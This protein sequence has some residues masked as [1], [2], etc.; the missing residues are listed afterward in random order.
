MAARAALTS[1]D[2]ALAVEQA[3]RAR[4][5]HLLHGRVR[6]AARAQATAGRSLRYW[7]RFGEARD[8][9]TAALA[10]LRDDPDADTVRALNEVA[11]VE[12]F[13][14]SPDADALSAE[15]L[16]RG[17]ALAVDDATLAGLFV[18]RG[19]YLI[20]VNRL[21]EGAAYLREAARLAGLAADTL[22]LSRARLNLASALTPADPAAGAAAARDAA[23]NARQVGARDYL[24]FAVINLAQALLMLGDWDAVIAE[25]GQAADAD[26][27]NMGVFTGYRAWVTALRGDVPNAQA[28]LAGLDELRASEDV[29]DQS[30]IAL[31]EAFTAA[32]RRQ[33]AAALCRARAAF[34]YAPTLGISHEA[35]RWAWP[36]AARAAWDLAD[37]QAAAELLALL[38]RY[39]PGELSPMLRAERDLARAR[40][41]TLGDDQDVAGTA[42]AS[43]AAGLRRQS[44]PYHL[45]HGLLDHAA[46]LTAH[47]DPQAAAAAISEA[48]AI[49]TKLGCEP[50]LSRAASLDPAGRP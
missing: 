41:A 2:W 18:T 50:L 16:V 19:I 48:T 1:G 26:G 3:G 28:A 40:L 11:T 30:T 5:D 14:G 13:A 37:T 15:A 24:A 20:F 47:G 42:L 45:A 10:V 44:T 46:W 21:A 22:L 9:L 25:L 29:Q 27:L 38:D 36:L 33:P 23:A 8:Q 6:D 39:Q 49:A 12:A 35:P 4:E 31:V 43:A 34:D 7:G 17:Q 32:A